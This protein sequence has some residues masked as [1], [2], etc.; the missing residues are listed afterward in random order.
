M[1][2]G[3]YES[4]T[5][6][7]HLPMDLG[8]FRSFEKQA[9]GETTERND[10][11][12]V[13]DFNLVLKIIAGASFDFIGQRITVSWRTA[14][15]HIRDPHI[16]ACYASLFEQLIQE[17]P[18]RADKWTSLLVFMETRSL[19]NEHNLRMSWPFARDCLL[20]GTM[21]FTFCTDYDLL[22]KLL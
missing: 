11:A 8:N 19:A 14:F 9:H 15:D 17:F 22:C 21:K 18:R 20:T 4:V 2:H 13:D 10:D 12:W 1:V 6:F 16:C 7:S 3:D 5:H